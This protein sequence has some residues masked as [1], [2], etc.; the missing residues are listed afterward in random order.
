MVDLLNVKRVILTSKTQSRQRPCA[1]LPD[2]L[3]RQPTAVA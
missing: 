3:R 1:G 2:E